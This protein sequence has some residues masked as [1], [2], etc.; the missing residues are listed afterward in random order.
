M[1]SSLHI[2]VRLDWQQSEPLRE[3]MQERIEC[4]TQWFPTISCSIWICGG[5]SSAGQ[6]FSCHVCTDIQCA[7]DFMVSSICFDRVASWNL[8]SGKFQF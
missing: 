3:C 6:E 2:S 1:H 4:K 8:T 7:F 5:F